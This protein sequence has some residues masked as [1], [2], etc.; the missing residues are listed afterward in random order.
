M[1]LEEIIRFAQTFN[2]NTIKGI[3]YYGDIED[4]RKKERLSHF[5]E[6]HGFFIDMDNDRI[7]LNLK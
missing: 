2:V 6:K 7:I 1:L 5:Y 3:I 4:S